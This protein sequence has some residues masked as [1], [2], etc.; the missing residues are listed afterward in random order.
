MKKEENS[1][2]RLIGAV[3]AIFQSLIDDLLGFLF[4]SLKRLGEPEAKMSKQTSLLKKFIKF[5]GDL[6]DSFYVTYEKI[7]KEKKD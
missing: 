3:L 2:P 6:G 4:K 1:I 7:K 5:F